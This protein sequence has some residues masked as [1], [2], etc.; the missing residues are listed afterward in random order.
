MIPPNVQAAVETIK[1][2]PFPDLVIAEVCGECNLCC[3]MCP[4][5]HLKRSRGIMNW[6]V[7]TKIVDEIAEK[8]FN[9]Q[10]WPAIMGEPLLLQHRIINYIEYA[11][12]K[13]IRE[14]ILNTN[15]TLLTPEIYR[16]LVAVKLDKIIVGLDAYSEKTYNAIRIGGDF[17]KIKKNLV[18]ILKAPVPGTEI[19]LQFIE[20]NEN[21]HETGQFKKYWLSKGATLKIRKKLGWGTCVEPHGFDIKP[22]SK[23]RVPCTWL[24]RAM[25]IHWTGNVAQ[26]DADYEGIYSVGDIRTQSIEEVWNGEF[27]RR[28]ARHWNGDFDF[29]PCRECKDWQAGLSEWYYPDSKAK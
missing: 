6:D 27:K 25:N 10:L 12:K 8:S 3:I 9:T 16:E 17:R 21:Q 18:E 11:K 2:L 5:P 14:V 4:S 20:M 19:I 28:R 15:A 29:M 26:C 23:D 1:E 24:M 22:T 7:Y 13:G